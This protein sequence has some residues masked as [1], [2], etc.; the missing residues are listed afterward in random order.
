MNDKKDIVETNLHPRDYYHNE[1]CRIV[2]PKQSMLYI[3]HKLFP[4]DMYTSIDGKTG[5]D[6]IVMI[7]DKEESQ[8]LYQAWCNHELQ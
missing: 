4:I 7:F 2:N 8:E 5:N 6:I 1:V 3:K